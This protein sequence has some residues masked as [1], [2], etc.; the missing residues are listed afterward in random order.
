MGFYPT[1]FHCS[2]TLQPSSPIPRGLSILLLTSL[3]LLRAQLCTALT[4]SFPFQERPF[5]TLKHLVFK[6]QILYYYNIFILL[7]PLLFKLY[8]KRG[9][10]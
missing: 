6:I 5:P 9:E 1:H 8:I 2:T 10:G 7:K 3:P 4:V